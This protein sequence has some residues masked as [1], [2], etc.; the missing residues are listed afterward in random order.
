M[1]NGHV[2]KSSI[3]Q[4]A[5][6]VFKDMRY[7]DLPFNFSQQEIYDICAAE[8]HLDEDHDYSKIH[9]SRWQNGDATPLQQKMAPL[10]FNPDLSPMMRRDLSKSPKTLLITCQ[11]DPLRDE[12]YWY[13]RRL[14]KAGVDVAW[15]HY[16]KAFHAIAN[17]HDELDL[18]ARMVG[19]VVS[20]INENL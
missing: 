3:H 17:L 8:S 6:F 10:L 2:H 5:P 7:S 18:A 12:G 19:D 20:F 15:K 11:Y 14:Q 1:Q 4:R 16:E 13:M 9:T